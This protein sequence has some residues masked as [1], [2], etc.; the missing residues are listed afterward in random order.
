M[1]VLNKDVDAVGSSWADSADG[2]VIGQ[3]VAEV[4][5]IVRQDQSAVAPSPAEVGV[6]SI[7][8]ARELGSATLAAPS[9]E[10]PANKLGV[11]PPEAP[12]N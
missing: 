2:A 12:K 4:A 7:K 6:L 9:I 5:P 10:A 3:A 8:T 11:K 1:T